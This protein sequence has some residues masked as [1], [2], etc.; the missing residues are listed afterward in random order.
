MDTDLMSAL[1]ILSELSGGRAGQ[2]MLDPYGLLGP[3]PNYYDPYQIYDQDPDRFKAKSQYAVKPNIPNKPG[4]V[5]QARQTLGTLGGATEAAAGLGEVAKARTAAIA[6]GVRGG[7]KLMGFG[8]S[9]AGNA[10]RLAMQALRNPAM[11]VGLKFAGPAAAAFAAGDLILGDESLANKGM[12]V[13]MMTAGGALGSFVPV[14]G[15]AL[16]AGLGKAASDAIQFVGGGGKSPEQRRMEEALA[17][18]Q[19]RGVV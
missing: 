19:A 18:L 16:G 4:P 15:T 10:G 14:V 3:T 17:L 13:A 2:D 1:A 5:R 12:D 9:A 7:S 8:P 11:Q 6:K